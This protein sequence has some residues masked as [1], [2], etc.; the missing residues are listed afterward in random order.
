MENTKED[1]KQRADATWLEIKRIREE[2]LE[3]YDQGEPLTSERLRV[4]SKW[5]D[6]DGLLLEALD[7]QLE[8]AILQEA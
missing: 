8:E 6:E 1:L 3:L 2:I 4:L 5:I 7:R